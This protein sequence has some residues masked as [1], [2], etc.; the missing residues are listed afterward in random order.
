[1]LVNGRRLRQT[2]GMKTLPG[3]KIIGFLAIVLTVALVVYAASPDKE[4]A[5]GTSPLLVIKLG[6]EADD[7]KDVIPAPWRYGWVKGLVEKAAHSDKTKFRIRHYEND[8]LIEYEGTLETCS[9]TLMAHSSG[10][11]PAPTATP[12][13][14]PLSPPGPSPQPSAGNTKTQTTAVLSFGN[15]SDAKQLLSDLSKGEPKEARKPKK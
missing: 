8:K 10:G 12:T 2:G 14:T 1:M 6:H 9:E 3:I 11:G 5:S 15:L 7:V 4:S 13:A